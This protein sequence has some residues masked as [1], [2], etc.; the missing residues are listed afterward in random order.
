MEIPVNIPGEKGWPS[1]VGF[2][3]KGR[4]IFIHTSVRTSAL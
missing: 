3:E 1:G 2:M 4:R